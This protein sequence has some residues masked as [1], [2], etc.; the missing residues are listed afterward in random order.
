MKPA[1]TRLPFM[2]ECRGKSSSSLNYV[3]FRSLLHRNALVGGRTQL[4]E[5]AVESLL[6]PHTSG[7]DTHYL[8]Q[9]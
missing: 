9:Q 1:V 3:L 8:R 4:S 6:F 5:E 2:R 7:S